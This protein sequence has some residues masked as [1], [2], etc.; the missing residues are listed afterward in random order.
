MKAKHL[1]PEERASLRVLANN[2]KM[3]EIL[4]TLASIAKYD[5]T[6][7]NRGYDLADEVSGRIIESV[8]LLQ[9]IEALDE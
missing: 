9:E 3:S 1:T 8:K 2:V 6:E 4:I 7:G 5:L